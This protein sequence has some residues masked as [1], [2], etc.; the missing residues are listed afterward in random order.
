MLSS[1][2]F[3]VA[4]AVMVLTA[5]RKRFAGVTSRSMS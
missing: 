3:W 1:D 2:R 5:P 4:R